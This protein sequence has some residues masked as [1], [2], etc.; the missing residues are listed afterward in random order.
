MGIYYT[1]K[2]LLPVTQL[3]SSDGIAKD[4]TRTLWTS[5]AIYYGVCAFLVLF[6]FKGGQEFAKQLKAA[7]VE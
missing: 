6:L 7:K 3:N 5:F 2:Y 1:N 4:D